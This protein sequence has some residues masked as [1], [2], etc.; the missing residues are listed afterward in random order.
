MT[1]MD[2]ACVLLLWPTEETNSEDQ[3]KSTE[4]T[5]LSDM[6][7]V[8]KCHQPEFGWLHSYKQALAECFH[9]PSTF[10]KH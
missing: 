7:Q 8:R 1:Q 5:D 3:M 2:A 10:T 6:H 9:S 4:F